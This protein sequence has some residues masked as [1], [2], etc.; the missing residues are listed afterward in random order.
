MVFHTFEVLPSIVLTTIRA[1][2]HILCLS[3]PLLLFLLQD[4]LALICHCPLYFLRAGVE[5]RAGKIR[6]HVLLQTMHASG[7]TWKL[8]PC[9]SHSSPSTKFAC[10][11]AGWTV[12]QQPQLCKVVWAAIAGVYLYGVK[13]GSSVEVV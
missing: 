10:A 4:V 11:I 12:E 1:L 13:P 6:D 2:I 7:I 9:L 5:P 3:I 8:D